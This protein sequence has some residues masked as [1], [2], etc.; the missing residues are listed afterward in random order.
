MAT[1]K[2]KKPRS[3]K[4]AKE[5]PVKQHPAKKTD[6]KKDSELLIQLQE[7][8]GFD[9]FKGPQEAIINNLLAGKDTFVIMPTGG[10]KSLCYQLPAIISEGC[11]IL[12]SSLI[13]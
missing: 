10:G 12:V 1:V 6:R 2:E 3:A 8:F 9:K 4:A 5:A 7:N 11:A 13:A